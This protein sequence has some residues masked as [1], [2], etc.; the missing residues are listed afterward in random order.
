MPVIL[1]APGCE[2]THRLKNGGDALKIALLEDDPDQLVL[3]QRWLQQE[4]HE[5]SAYSHGDKFVEMVKRDTYDL[6]LL[7]WMVP[8]MDGFEVM[9]WARE[10]LE[11]RIPIIF[12][13]QRDTEEDVVRALNAGADD[14]MTKPVKRREMLARIDALG[15]RTVGDAE[16]KQVLELNPYLIDKSQHS[17]SKNGEPIELTPRE[18]DLALFFFSNWG[19]VLSRGY[20]LQSVWGRSPN[21]QTRTVDTHISRLRSKLELKP[22]EGWQLTSVYHHGYRMEK[23]TPEPEEATSAAP[24]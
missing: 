8:D 24:G 4:G 6:L 10:N 22:E 9:R 5:C 7:D 12:V 15:R 17:I 23:V 14:Y 21:L 19:R 20:I 18:Y 16:E 1:L 2:S 3:M 13:T 11:W